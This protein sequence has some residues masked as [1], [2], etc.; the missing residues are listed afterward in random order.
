MAEDDE[1]PEYLKEYQA[2]ELFENVDNFGP[3]DMAWSGSDRDVDDLLA[4]HGQDPYS[5]LQ[6]LLFALIRGSSPD[7]RPHEVLSRTQKAITAITGKPFPT[8][9]PKSDYHALLLEIGWLYYLA[10]YDN[11]LKDEGISLRPIVQSVINRDTAKIERETNT[12]Y[13]SLVQTLERKFRATRD[14]Y[15]ARATTDDEW[16]RAKS[17]SNL[18]EGAKLLAK[19]GISIEPLAIAPVRLAKNVKS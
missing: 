14:V 1:V 19:A 13:E 16:G 4:E 2:S 6:L 18:R 15:L 10:L 17:Y 7:I 12:S 5:P 9:K 3:E 11:G 8:G